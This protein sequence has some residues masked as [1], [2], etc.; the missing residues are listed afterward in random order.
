MTT[1][2]YIYKDKYQRRRT[3]LETFEYL[4]AVIK[5][6]LPIDYISPTMLT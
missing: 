3:I 2:K 6:V 4:S 5:V 1:H